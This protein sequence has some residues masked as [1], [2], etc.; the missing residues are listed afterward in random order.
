VPMDND[1]LGELSAD[2]L[3]EVVQ[4]VEV[5]EEAQQDDSDKNDSDTASSAK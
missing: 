5:P 1:S 3:T 2:D 4:P